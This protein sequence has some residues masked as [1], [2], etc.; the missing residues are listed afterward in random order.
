MHMNASQKISAI[1]DGLERRGKPG[2]LTQVAR[3]LNVAP[4]TVSRWFS[5]V[6]EPKGRQ[7]E[8]LDLLYRTVVQAN[9]DNPD[10]KKILGAILGGLGAGLLGIGVG[11]ILIAAG[12]GWLLS[13]PEEEEEED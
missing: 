11:G 7:L 5:G 1:I 8:A 2:T 3:L 12:L 9:Q 13:D 4:S 10:A 6:V